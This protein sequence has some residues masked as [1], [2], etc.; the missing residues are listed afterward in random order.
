MAASRSSASPSPLAWAAERACLCTS[1]DAVT[2]FESALALEP[3]DVEAAAGLERAQ[4]ELAAL[5][6]ARRAAQ[7]AQQ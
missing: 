4:A 6:E 1:Q 3:T 7:A 5:R 2:Y